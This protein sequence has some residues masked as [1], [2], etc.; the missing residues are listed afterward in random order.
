MM[1]LHGIEGGYPSIMAADTPQPPVSF[2]GFPNDAAHP[3]TTFDQ[4][5]PG[6]LLLNFNV[7]SI[8]FELPRAALGGGVIR[9]WETTSVATGAPNFNF[10]QQDRLARPAINE[11]LATV[12]LS[13]HDMNN[14]VNPTDDPNFIMKDILAFMNYPAGR[15]PLIANTLASVLVPDVMVAD[16]SKP[17][18]ASYLGYEVSKGFGGRA[19]TSDVVD[20]DLMA[21]FG[22]LIPTVTG[23]ADDGKETPQLSTDNIG[24]HG[25][26]LGAFPYLG[27][28]G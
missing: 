22:N 9:L 17:G 27:N 18:P 21:I 6:D 10:V 25:D 19:L 8:V 24:P 28:P 23:V 11:V 4:S 12:S 1:P 26:Y 5:A 3:S 20:T 16:L 2:R 15:S 13:R 7:L 14:R